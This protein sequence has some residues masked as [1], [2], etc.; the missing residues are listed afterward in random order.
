MGKAKTKRSI[1]DTLLIE[2]DPGVWEWE[3]KAGE[4]TFRWQ[5][6][7]RPGINTFMLKGPADMDG[8]A[9]F[10]R[11]DQAVAYMCGFTDGLAEHARM[12]QAAMAAA[13]E[14][15]ITAQENAK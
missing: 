1:L 10:A 6:T 2:S 8:V 13:R 9:F 11:I 15:R 14:A 4:F 5:W 7:G 12:A 3:T